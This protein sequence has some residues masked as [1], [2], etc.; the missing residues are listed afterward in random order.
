MSMAAT[1]DVCSSSKQSRK[2]L[3]LE[4]KMGSHQCPSDFFG[5]SESD[6]Y[7]ILILYCVSRTV[8]FRKLLRSYHVSPSM[9]K[10]TTLCSNG[11]VS[12]AL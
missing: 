5:V 11:F 12:F 2:F 1:S 9:Q 6:V 4:Q 3:T 8:R 7:K 10:S